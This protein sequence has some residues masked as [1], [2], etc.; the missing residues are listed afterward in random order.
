MFSFFKK[1]SDKK[2]VISKDELEE[3]LY[4]ADVSYELIEELLEDFG[5]QI[6]K[7]ELRKS[8]LAIFEHAKKKASSQK[9]KPNNPQ[10]DM[11]IGVNGAGKTTTIAKLAS[12]HKKQGKSVLLAAADTFR[13]AAVEQLTLWATK[14]DVSI[15]KAQK[16]ADPSSVVFN[17]L[18][19]ALAK[20]ANHVIIDTAGRMQ[21]QSNLVQELGKMV[22]VA[23][24]VR[25]DFPHRKI[26]I[27]DGMQGGM[28]IEQA[29]V[30]S[31]HI[32][33]DGV[34]ITKL[35]GTSK[36]GAILSIVKELHIPVLYIGVGED[37]DDLLV[38]SSEEYVDSI[39]DSIYGAEDTNG[40]E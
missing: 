36:G 22:R 23:T 5:K 3:A 13:A 39:L 12:L 19:S 4:N 32:G 34:I 14:L 27:I 15:I 1:T 40:K 25:E 9:D 28:A 2:V 33:V 20:D 16:G 38:F 29:K 8:L 26:L 35:D 31:E 7:E 37:S 24:K 6:K 11:I 18:Q 21:S 30:F 10:V 17:A